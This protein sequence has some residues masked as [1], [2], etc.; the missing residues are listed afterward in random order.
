MPANERTW[1]ELD[2]DTFD[3]IRLSLRSYGLTPPVNDQGFIRGDR[4][5]VDVRYEANARTLN[6]NIRELTNGDTNDSFFRKIDEIIH[7]TESA[8]PG[9]HKRKH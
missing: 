8:K 4:V 9:A 6:L 7:R 1:T 2:K 3:A 5:V